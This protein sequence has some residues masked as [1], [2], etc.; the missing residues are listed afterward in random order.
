[1]NPN[2]AI[3]E[4]ANEEIEDEEK[5]GRRTKVQIIDTTSEEAKKKFPLEKT[6]RLEARSVLDGRMY[7]G[8]FTIKKMS[9][10]AMGKKGV[11]KA[12]FNAG[13]IVDPQTDGLHE[14]MAQVLVSVTKA[15]NAD[16]FKNLDELADLDILVALYKEVVAFEASFRTPVGK[17]DAG[18]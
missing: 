18:A 17:R 2:Q 14:R 7:T 15:E 1:M 16:W 3:A 12:Q 9:L 4:Q 10:G 5:T 13:L 11:L 6:V 8:D